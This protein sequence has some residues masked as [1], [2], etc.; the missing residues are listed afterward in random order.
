MG[1]AGT[2]DPFASGILVL[3]MGPATRL[4]SYLSGGQKTY[5]LR[6]A[7]GRATDSL[8]CTGESIAEGVVNFDEAQLRAA[9]PNFLGEIEQRPPSLSAI[10]IDGVRA[11]VLHRRGEAPEEMPSRRVQIHDIDLL[12]FDGSE[13][14]LRV[15][16]GS[17]T[18]M[19][20]LARDLGEVLGCP[21][22]AS[23]LRRESVGVF[24]LSQASTPKEFERDW[25]GGEV[26]LPPE[27]ILSNWQRIEL[28]DQEVVAIRCGKQPD[29]SWLDRLT[30]SPTSGSAARPLGLVD[31]EGALVAVAERDDTRGLRL[32][33]VLG[34][35]ET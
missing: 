6:I 2:L 24:G 16:C 11:H 25:A 7:F 19:R 32:A 21:A 4:L 27:T 17:G 23:A 18:Y 26:A 31:G 5:D 1:H 14:R 8:D 13:A 28:D 29:V 9:L 10:H 20:S 33:M 34:R 30:P 3:A 15:R 22:H 35:S 12:S